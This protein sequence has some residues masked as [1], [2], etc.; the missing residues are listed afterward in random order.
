MVIRGGRSTSD[1]RP[2]TDVEEWDTCRPT[3][4]ST[5]EYAKVWAERHEQE[6]EK[7]SGFACLTACR[8][9]AETFR[10]GLGG[11]L[12]RLFRAGP[13]GVLF[14]PLWYLF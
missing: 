4:Q 7:A 12:L 2:I 6:A 8:C 1:I 9:G 5:A 14:T 11:M 3:S 10:A 13:R